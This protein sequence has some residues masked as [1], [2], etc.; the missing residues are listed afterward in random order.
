MLIDWNWLTI[1]A[2]TLGAL[3]FWLLWKVDTHLTRPGLQARMEG[4][5]EQAIK[6]ARDEFGIE[7]NNRL[8]SLPKLEEILEKFHQRHLLNPIEDRDLS[9]L[10]LTWGGYLG[11]TL[12]KEKG[13]SG[14]TTA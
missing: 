4:F 9:R 2:V 11:S 8:D 7:L 6:L 1:I 12:Q 5:A 13:A 3:G 10:V 14:K